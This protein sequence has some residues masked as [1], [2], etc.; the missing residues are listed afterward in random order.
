MRFLQY[1]TG[2]DDTDRRLDRV[3]RKFL[4]DMGLGE[5]YKAIRKGLIKINGHKTTQNHHIEEGDVIEIAEFLTA[6]SSASPKAP[7]NSFQSEKN[8]IPLEI[9]FRNEQ[10]L[11]INK[12]YD[13]PVQKAARGEKSLD[14]IVRSQYS[15]PDTSLSFSAGPLHR[16]D[17]KT[18]GV[19]CFSQNLQ[20]AREFSS[21]I[22]NHRI[23][24]TYVALLSG[25]LETE[26]TWTDFISKND[27]TD[28]FKTVSVNTTADHTNAKES[29]TMVTPLLAGTT[30]RSGKKTDVTLARINILTGRTHQIRSQCSAHGYPLLGDTAYNGGKPNP[31]QDF[32]LHALTLT[33]PQ[34][35]HLGPTVVTAPLPA[36]FTAF[37]TTIFDSQSLEKIDFFKIQPYNESTD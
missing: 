8:S 24:K 33:F 21:L 2:Q 27:E 18:T 17:K 35:S 6:G 20:G 31:G 34:E 28:G 9:L 3:L 32:F 14:D 25:R 36:A 15:S 26:Q 37:L 10:I 7:G 16:L 19:L 29:I 23:T 11:I 4:P 30:V 22:Q 12:P 5:L 1:K 13:I